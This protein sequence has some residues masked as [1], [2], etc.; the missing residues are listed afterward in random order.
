MPGRSANPDSNFASEIPRT[1]DDAAMATLEVPLANPIGSPKHVPASYYYKIP[2]R[3]IYKSY[4]LY[5]PGHEPPGYMD[6][7]NQQEPK[8]IWGVDPKTGVTHAPP[9][10]TEEDWIKAGEMVFD[11]PHLYAPMPPSAFYKAAG[12]PIAANGVVP[13]ESIVIRQKGKIE[14][15]VAGCLDCHTRVMPDGSVLKGAQGNNPSDRA[16]AFGMSVGFAIAKDKQAF[17]EST[18]LGERAQLEVPWL[19]PSDQPN[20]NHMSG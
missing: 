4:P 15:G 1:W 19:N 11:S 7:L 8:V 16:I 5:A 10:K 18:R 6:W 13:F 14:V 20:Y 17:V 12:K 3:P 2:V 9:L